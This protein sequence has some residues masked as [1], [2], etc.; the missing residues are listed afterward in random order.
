MSS[1]KSKIDEKLFTETIINEVQ[2]YPV[3]WNIA[4]QEYSKAGAQKNVKWHLIAE[5]VLKLGI[6]T[7]GKIFSP[8]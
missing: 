7:D 4:C 1:R 2:R 5:E 3:L 6:S 8:C